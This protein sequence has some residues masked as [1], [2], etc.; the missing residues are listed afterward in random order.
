LSCL[1][2]TKVG[3]CN[4]GDAQCSCTAQAKDCANG[5]AVQKCIESSCSAADVAKAGKASI[6]ICSD[7]KIDISKCINPPTEPTKP[8]EPTTP[9]EPT[10]P[11]EPTGGPAK[12]TGC[13][14]RYRA[15]KY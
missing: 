12:P 15:R 1:L 14:P 3:S 6:G 5:A 7:L 11:S 8:S 2:S 10:K 13:V 9:S 4:T